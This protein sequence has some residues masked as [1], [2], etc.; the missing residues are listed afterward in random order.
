LEQQFRKTIYDLRDPCLSDLRKT[1]LPNPRLFRQS[2]GGS[3]FRR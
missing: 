1:V 2:H 3:Y